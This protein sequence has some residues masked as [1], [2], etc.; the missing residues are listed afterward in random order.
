MTGL[1]SLGKLDVARNPIPS[2]C[3]AYVT[4]FGKTDTN[5]FSFIPRNHLYPLKQFMKAFKWF[6]YS[7]KKICIRLTFAHLFQKNLHPFNALAKTFKW[8]AHLFKKF[9]SV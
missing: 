4:F 6:A 8:F 1:Q 5:A 7:F 3:L 9:V 2:Y